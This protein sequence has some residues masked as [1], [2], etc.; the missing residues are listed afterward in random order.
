MNCLYAGPSF[1][2]NILDLILRFRL[3]KI[4][5]IGDIEK[6]FLMISVAPE[7]RDAL[8]FLWVDDTSV[9]FPQ[10]VEFRFA[11]VV[12]GALKYHVETFKTVDPI[13]VDKFSRSIYAD[14]FV[15][16]ADEEDELYVLLYVYSYLYLLQILFTHWK[17]VCLSW[18][19]IVVDFFLLI[20]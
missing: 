14:D 3:H 16:G 13:F 18:S 11:R 6:A 9:G 1:D 2:Q 5:I 19:C 15:S 8:R 20:S 12:F 7:D 17:L 10:I 4:A